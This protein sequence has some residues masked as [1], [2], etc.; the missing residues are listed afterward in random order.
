MCWAVRACVLSV[1]SGDMRWAV[2]PV[3]H[4][5][6]CCVLVDPSTCVELAT[7]SWAEDYVRLG[8][9]MPAPLALPPWLLNVTMVHDGVCARLHA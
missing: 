8:S 9:H 1:P 2:L 7:L 6:A 4:C 5:T 3:C